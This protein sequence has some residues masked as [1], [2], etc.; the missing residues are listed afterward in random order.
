MTSKMT[1]HPCVKSKE[2]A[3]AF[4]GSWSAISLVIQDPKHLEFYIWQKVI[5]TPGTSHELHNSTIPTLT[6]VWSRTL[7]FHYRT[8]NSCISL[9]DTILVKLLQQ[10]TVFLWIA[11]ADEG[12][13]MC[14][15]NLHFP[16]AFFLISSSPLLR[17]TIINCKQ[18]L[19]AKSWW[20]GGGSNYHEAM[21]FHKLPPFQSR[22]APHHHSQS[23]TE[24]LIKCIVL[25]WLDGGIRWKTHATFAHAPISSK[26][27]P[28]IT[29]INCEP[30]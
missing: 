8:I 12:V 22:P 24:A 5:C 18:T 30:W 1:S 29:F 20:L 19:N 4:H 27:L 17:F 21:C 7:G 2:C 11:L 10:K 6:P 25:N 26:L 13:M 15:S 3:V 9:E 16:I 23:S 14:W 28:S